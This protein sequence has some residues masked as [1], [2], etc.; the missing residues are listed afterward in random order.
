MKQNVHNFHD[1]KDASC[2][3]IEDILMDEDFLSGK[4]Y[5]RYILEYLK[6]HCILFECC[7][8]GFVIFYWEDKALSFRLISIF[9]LT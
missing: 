2:S 4:V 8:V 7:A 9:I 5:L 3:R 6:N 1:A